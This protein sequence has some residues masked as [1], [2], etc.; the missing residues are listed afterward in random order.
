M[1]KVVLLGDSI[2]MG[3]GSRVAEML[4]EEFEVW[5]PNDNCRYA[6]YTYQHLSDD[7]WDGWATNTENVDI[8][9]WNNGLWD[10]NHWFEDGPMTPKE[11]YVDTMIRIAKLLLR[12]AK[13]VI[14]ATITPVRDTN[15]TI[16]NSEVIDYNQALIP[17]LKKLG[18]VINDLHTLLTADIPRYILASDH[19]HLTED[20]VSLCS[21]Q[22][23]NVIRQQAKN[24]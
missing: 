22:V 24:L 4:G 17:E 18:V 20:G 13:I 15:P 1:K 10:V 9:H 16:T 2:R 6:Q 3:Y 21:T 7:E 11:F 8:I 23:A 5:Q 14:F 12:R 19:I